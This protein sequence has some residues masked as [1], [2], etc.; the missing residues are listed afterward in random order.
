MGKKV[1]HVI[2]FIIAGVITVFAVSYIS[3]ALYYRNGFS[4]G[5]WINGIYCTG[6]SIDEVNESLTSQFHYDGIKISGK[7]GSSYHITAD[8]I[9][10]SFDFKK[11]LKI[12]LDQQDCWLWPENLFAGHERKLLPVV[13]YDKGLLEKR[14]EECPLFA[15]ALSEKPEVR[16]Y[17]D[18]DKG[19]VLIDNSKDIL[20]TDK[21]MKAVRDAVKKSRTSVDLAS[22]KCYYDLEI[23]KEMQDDIDTYEKIRPIQEQDI[24]LKFGECSEKIDSA[25]ASGFIRRS[26]GDQ[27]YIG[28]DGNA[29]IDRNLVKAYIDSLALKYNTVGITRCFHCTSGRDV[30]ILGGTYGNML[31]R[32]GELERLLGQLEKQEKVSEEPLYKQK[33]VIQGN[34]DDIGNTY[35]EVDMSA[36]ELYYYENGV[37]KISTPVV[38]GN[39]QL[40]RGTPQGVNFVAVKQKNRTFHGANYISHV[41][42]WMQVYKGIGIHDSSWRDDYGGDIYKT[43]GSHGC[44]NTPYDKMLELYNDVEV[45]TPVVMFY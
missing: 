39:I 19:Y 34:K 1:M 7:D 17:Y 28:K 40:K 14:L 31:D 22:S 23:T 2:L 30:S 37:I 27:I 44:I 21:G 41:K 10:Y 12:Y 25:V 8:D 15:K 11:A 16:L 9:G 4:Y 20:D 18:K 13:S 36:Q 35:I 43:G 3:L 32:D 5:T 33:A 24:E 42:L 45:G 38:T 26:D 6:K 29:Q